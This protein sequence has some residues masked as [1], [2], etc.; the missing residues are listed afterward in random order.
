MVKP[1]AAQDR[2][3]RR[4]AP[5]RTTGWRSDAR[6]CEFARNR[7]DRH[8]G[9]EVVDDAVDDSVFVLIEGSVIAVPVVASAVKQAARGPLLLSARHA[10]TLVRG[11]VVGERDQLPG[12][13]AALVPVQVEGATLDRLDPDRAGVEEVEELLEFAG[14]PVEP[15]QMPDDDCRCAGALDLA[16]E[17]LVGRSCPVLVGGDGFV[18]ELDRARISK[19]VR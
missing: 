9:E 10:G 8:A 3:H 7:G 5:S 4:R 11:L 17:L 1:V 19:S 15:V 6:I 14:A 13:Q 16:E 18:D 2:H 12:E